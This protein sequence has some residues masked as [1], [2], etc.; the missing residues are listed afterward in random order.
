MFV[1]FLKLLPIIFKTAPLLFIINQVLAIL[2]GISWSVI[3]FS[4]QNFFDTADDMINGKQELQQLL[5]ALVFMGVAYTCCQILNGVS[6]FVPQILASKSQ[7]V[8]GMQ[9]HK[10]IANIR[11]ID[12]ENTDS[13]DDINKANVGKDNAIQYVIY[14]MFL[15]TFYI[16]YFFSMTL[17]LFTIKPVLAISILLIFIPT[18]LVQILRSKVFSKLEDHSAP[19]RR[20]NDYYAS[21]IVEREYFKETRLLGNATFFKKLFTDTLL[22]LNNLRMKAFV[23]VNRA[24]LFM[25]LLTIA[26]YFGIL[27]MLFFYLMRREITV[28]A[29]AAVFSSVGLLFSVMEEIVC[30][31][32]GNMAQNLGTIRN[33][34]N[35]MELEMHSG[36][37]IHI[38]RTKSIQFDH[39][40]FAYPV[41]TKS[42][43]KDISFEIIPG[44][45][46]ALVG[47]NGSG[48]ST[49]VRLLLGLYQPCSGKVMYGHNNSD[50]MSYASLFENTSVVFQ[51]FQKYQMT[52]QD[53]ICISQF[54]KP[55]S[56]K[57]LDEICQNSGLNLTDPIFPQGADTMLSREF[58]N[59]DLSG[60]YWQK[61]S[62]ARALYRDHDL[63]VLDEPTSAIDPVEETHI[64]NR[65]AEIT[66][67]KTS[68]IV[69]H[70]LGSVQ[71]A[72]RIV[73][74]KEGMIC[75]IGNHD[76]LMA[77]KGEYY[78]LFNAQKQW[79]EG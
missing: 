11:A 58:G 39:V 37:D 5:F 41:S 12:Y 1:L 4:N 10:K 72:D 51:K 54:D 13:M 22:I 67:D 69:T 71:L 18:F 3:S 28:G 45:T 19:V 66:K 56:D 65:F 31:H 26:G 17:Y 53:N 47:E 60:G 40:Y 79:Y 14:F 24:E 15:F 78:T 33:Y 46:I 63:I 64:Y 27:Y 59:I 42:V 77:Q 76:E 61:I 73:V 6:N 75:E 74:L 44:E 25:K 34:I 36:E 8:L 70:R 2:Q 9:I 50:V 48:K 7:G 55:N 57:P 68:V 16:P 32:F 20:E 43:L 52:L 62:I 21:C 29:F 30:R 23:R 38:D 35:F 49:L